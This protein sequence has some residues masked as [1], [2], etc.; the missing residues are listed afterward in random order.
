MVCRWESAG[1]VGRISSEPAGRKP[2]SGMATDA[3]IFARAE[4]CVNSYFG[5]KVKEP[6]RRE[7]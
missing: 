6:R 2:D 5:K 7:L 1:G 4:P 3:S